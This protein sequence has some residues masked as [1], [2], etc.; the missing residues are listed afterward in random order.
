MAHAL[1]APSNAHRWLECPGSVALEQQ[2]PDASSQFA[3]EGTA[4]HVLAAAALHSGQSDEARA[5]THATAAA[6]LGGPPDD[7]MLR[8]VQTYVDYVRAL[9]RPTLI[10]QRLP[11][12]HITGEEGAHGT[13]DAVVLDAPEIVVADLKYGRGVRVDAEDNPQ[14]A[15]YACAALDEYGVLGE[16]DRVRMVIV[17]PRLEH[18]SEWVLSR[19]ELEAFRARAAIGAQRATAALQYHANYGALHDKYLNPGEEQC[20]FCRAKAVCPALGAH[21]LATVSDDFVALDKP[22][23]PQIEPALSRAYDNAV[24]GNLLGAIDLIETWCKSVRAKGESELLAGKEVPGWKLVEGRRGARRWADDGAAE[25][26]L[27]DVFRLK[28]EEV[29]DLKLIS[30]TLAEKLAKTGVIGPRQ[31]PKL[32]PLITQSEGS[33]SVAPESDKRPALV[34]RATADEFIDETLV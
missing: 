16:F 22:V 20:R 18:V 1:L 10:E 26:M 7:E 15:L 14:L 23:A 4:A 5:A 9:N 28:V 32:L 31:W 11:I 21:V 33:P 24:L 12:A 19:D 29:Y 25:H 2:C 6:L 17:Q 27:R 30:P 13:A 8:H 34:V 3:D